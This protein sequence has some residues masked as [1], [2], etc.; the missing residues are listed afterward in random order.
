MLRIDKINVKIDEE[1]RLT[2]QKV[3]ETLEEK[4][5]KAASSTRF[6]VR[7][8]EMGIEILL[9]E[10]ISLPT[11]NKILIAFSDE[12][13]IIKKLTWDR[14]EIGAFRRGYLEIIVS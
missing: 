12:R 3:R 7:E 14:K 9:E 4:L 5:K 13:M 10:P 8:E 1:S 11:V 6:K 2:F